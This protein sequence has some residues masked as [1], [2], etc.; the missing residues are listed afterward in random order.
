MSGVLVFVLVSQ[1][2]PETGGDDRQR[3]GQAEELPSGP[4]T[5]PASPLPSAVST[6]TASAVLPQD[7]EG[8]EPSSPPSPEASPSATASAT[9]GEE[10][11]PEPEPE[12]PAPEPQPERPEPEPTETE[13]EEPVE[14]APVPWW[15]W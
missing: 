10:P 8:E 15:P 12:Q 4:A 3:V 6:P 5:D 13:D 14:E 2:P 7:D 1:A 11:E 9:S